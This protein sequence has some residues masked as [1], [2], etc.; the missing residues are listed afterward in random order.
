MYPSVRRALAVI[1]PMAVVLAGI[2]VPTS[3][4]RADELSSLS[5]V[6]GNATGG[7]ISLSAQ[8]TPFLFT[9]IANA[10]DDTTHVNAVFTSGS[11]TATVTVGS[12]SASA[13]VTLTSGVNAPIPLSSGINTIEVTHTGAT[14]TTYTLRITRSWRITGYEIIDADDSTVLVSKTGGSFDPADQDDTLLVGHDVADVR[15][16]MFYG[17]PTEASALPTNATVWWGCGVGCSGPSTVTSGTWT[18]PVPLPVGGSTIGLYASIN[19]WYPYEGTPWSIVA[20][21]QAAYTPD[22]LSSLSLVDGNATG[23]AIS[24][25][26]QSTPFLFTGIANAADD[27]THVNAVFTSGSATATVTVGSG[28]A[29]APVTLTSGV[30][31]PIPLSSGINTIEV[32]HTG[33]TTTTYTL[34]ITRSWRITGYEIIDADDSTVLVSKT[35]GSFDP[36]DQ[37]DTLLVGHDVADVRV[38]MFYGTPTEASALPTNATVWWGC[39]VGCSGPSTVTSGT[40]T[41]PVPLPVGG[42]TIGLYASINNWYPYEG[43]QWSIVATRASAFSAITS[44]TLPG[45]LPPLGTPVDA[46]SPITVTPAGVTGTPTP[47]VTY[48]WEAADDTASPFTVVATTTVP[49]WTPDETV[50]D[51]V[52]RV[53]A[54]ADNGISAPS[55]VTSPVFGPIRMVPTAPTIASA[56]LSGT[57]QVGSTL[58]VSTTGVSGY[59]TPTLTYEWQ[60]SPGGGSFTEISGETSS[61][62]TLRAADEGRLVRAIVTATNATSPAATATTAASG[63]IAAGTASPAPTPTPGRDGT[64]GAPQGVEVTPWHEALEVRWSAAPE[65]EFPTTTYRVTA[66]KASCLTDDLT[67]TLA[68][69]VNG[70]DYDVRVQALNGSGWGKAAQVSARPVEGSMTVE[71]SREHRTV[72][73]SGSITGFAPSDDS[74][75]PTVHVWMGKQW[76]VTRKGMSVSDNG[77]FSWKRRINP[78]KSF[79]LFLAYESVTTRPIAFKGKVPTP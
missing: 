46:G 73:V 66:G 77:D 18:D 45:S 25:S 16:R 75:V 48:E 61:T 28:S 6:D 47:T 11:A 4:A 79:A 34:R 71:V 29:S 55:S 39:G 3:A 67:C 24:L 22:T 33:A 40:W 51:K 35:G 72:T 19:N 42:S 52:L 31:A 49:S 60:S 12:G 5:L 63:V 65:G 30:N 15:V 53:T 27:T 32:T 36:A 41:D 59:P 68:G 10:A 1:A 50:A 7:A 70:R 38:R 56:S 8:S 74:T 69:L 20:T 37:D 26:A 21:R 57:E 64:P 58:T 78:S 13:P 17:T 76:I 62:Y 9:G 54:T 2:L 44:V 23:G 14:T 43:T